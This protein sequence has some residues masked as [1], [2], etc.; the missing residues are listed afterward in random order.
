L[1][2]GSLAEM[3]AGRLV[4]DDPRAGSTDRGHA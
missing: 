4:E 3:A 2:L 1:L